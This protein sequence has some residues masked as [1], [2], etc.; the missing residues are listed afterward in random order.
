MSFYVGNWHFSDLMFALG[1]VL[2][3]W[4]PRCKW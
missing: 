3:G 1:D 4:L 2:C